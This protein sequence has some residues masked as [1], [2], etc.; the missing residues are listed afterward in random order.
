M[1]GLAYLRHDHIL[2]FLHIFAIC[3]HNGLQKAQVFHMAA[4]R[5][6]AVHKMLHHP[7]ADFVAQMVVARED[8]PHGLRL[9]EL[10]EK[11]RKSGSEETVCA[12]V[13]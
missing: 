8:V 4:V 7:L 13:K 3:L 11:Q 12:D 9:K 6:Y 1:A 5:L 2:A 10:I